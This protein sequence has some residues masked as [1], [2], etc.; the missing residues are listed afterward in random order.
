MRRAIDISPALAAL[1]QVA[2]EKARLEAAPAGERDEPKLAALRG[3]AAAAAENALAAVRDATATGA[4]VDRPVLLPRLGDPRLAAFVAAIARAADRAE[5]QL[6]AAIGTTP[7]G[8]REAI[9]RIDAEERRL[10]AERARLGEVAARVEAE[11]AG[12]ARRRAALDARL[13]STTLP[14][15]RQ[16]RAAELARIEA[17][18]A[19]NAAYVRDVLAPDQVALDARAARLAELRGR[20][21]RTDATS[22]RRASPA[23]PEERAAGEMEG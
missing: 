5:D 7:E 17:A 13:R 21:G 16:G 4:W 10:A 1:E 20:L 23:G 8:V 3:A 22:T 2:A 19:Q 12:L 11:N 9:A 18:I 14:A 15:I 6:I